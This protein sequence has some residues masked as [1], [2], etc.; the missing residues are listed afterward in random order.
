MIMQNIMCCSFGLNI[1]LGPELCLR[2]SAAIQF[3]GGTHWALVPLF[4]L[5]RAR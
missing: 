3:I 1:F 2:L 5:I 4:G